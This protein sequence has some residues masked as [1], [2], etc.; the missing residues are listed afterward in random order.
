VHTYFVQLFAASLVTALALAGAAQAEE[1][2][3]DTFSLRLGGY[4]IRNADTVMRLDANNAPLGTYIDFADTLG[5]ERKATIVRMDGLYRFN[6]RHGLGFSWYQMK[7][8]GSRVLERD[9]QW[10]G[11]TFPAG[12]QVDSKLNFDVTKVNYQYSL[13]HNEEAELGASIGL[14]VM[15]VSAS[16]NGNT[17][18]QGQSITAPLPVWGLYAKYKFTPRFSAYYNYEIFNINYQD[19]VSGGL[20]DFLFGLEYRLFRNF[21]LGAAYNRFALHLKGKGD[22]TTVNL[23]TSWNGGMLYGAVYF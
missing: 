19:K 18:S 4:N 23:D 10:G 13:F 9:I 15:G 7:L 17:Q 11:Q 1:K 21:A 16:I 22:A 5:G 2:L 6:E 12:S 3:P 20:Q 14:H 8:T